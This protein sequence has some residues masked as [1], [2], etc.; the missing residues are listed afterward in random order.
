MGFGLPTLSMQQAG[1]EARTAG[2]A[3][4]S[5]ETTPL[6]PARPFRERL[7]EEILRRL[8]ATAH[9]R[10]GNRKISDP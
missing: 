7:P 9:E 3:Q 8:P 1:A 5:Q 10:F 4:L 6:C 2:R